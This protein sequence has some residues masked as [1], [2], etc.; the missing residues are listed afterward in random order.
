VSSACFKDELFF[1]VVSSSC[2]KGDAVNA[3]VR[4]GDVNV[5]LP[6]STTHKT[7]QV[8]DN[9]LSDEDDN[10]GEATYGNVQ[11]NDSL[12]SVQYFVD[13]YMAFVFWHYIIYSF[14]FYHFGLLLWYLQTLYLIMTN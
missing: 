6:P 14:S 5:S 2:F 3:T 12:S 8:Y 7:E 4:T 11:L 9:T 13:H 1:T 10:N